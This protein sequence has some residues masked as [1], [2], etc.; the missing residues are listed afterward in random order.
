M[1]PEEVMHIFDM[2]EKDHEEAK[3]LIAKIEGTT[4]RA[5]KTREQAFAKLSHALEMHMQFEEKVVY[6]ALRKIPQFKDQIAE[7]VEEHSGA[8][9]ILKK[10]QRTDPGEEEWISDLG[11]L[12]QDLEH[13]IKEEETELFPQSRK[14]LGEERGEEMGAQYREMKREEKQAA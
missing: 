13:H 12:K 8:K 1:P 9:K 5:R 4:E 7:A 2:L 14:P 10:L 3:A 6:P 11:H